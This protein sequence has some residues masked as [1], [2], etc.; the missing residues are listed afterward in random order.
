MSVP[1]ML[2]KLFLREIPLSVKIP[3]VPTPVPV[4]LVFQRIRWESVVMTMSVKMILV[5]FRDKI[6][7]TASIWWAVFHVIVT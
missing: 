2:V 4:T 7:S 5:V 3:P 1:L 6:Q